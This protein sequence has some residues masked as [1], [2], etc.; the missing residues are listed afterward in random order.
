MDRSDVEEIKARLPIEEVVG[1]YVKLEKAG[2][3]FKAK[4][5]FHGEK[6]ASFF[7]SPDRG[8]YYCFGCGAKGDI[9]S[10]VEQ[11][12]GLDFKGALKVLAERAGVALR[13]GVPSSA[14]SE[15]EGLFRVME[16][17][18][19][20]FEDRYAA[21]KEAQEYIAK[22][23]VTD[24]TRAEFRIG[25]APEGWHGLHEHLKAKK[26]PN[27]LIEKAGLAKRSEDGTGNYYD[28]F[29][30][31]VMFPLSDS[32][33]RVIAF[34]GRILPRLDDGKTGKYINSPDTP[35]FDKSSVL[36]GLDK[37]KGA[38][39]RLGYSIIVEG[40][41]DLVMSHQAG[42]KNTV[43]ASGTAL[44]DAGS[45]RN[46]VTNNLGL[47]RR[48]AGNAI[49]AFDSDAAGRKAAMRAAGIALSL[50]MDVKIADLQGGKDPADLVL[51]DPEGWKDAL[52][53]AKPIVEFELSNVL[54]DVPD[55][56]KVPKALRER[57]LPFVAAMESATDKAYAVKLISDASDLP[58]QAL[59]DDLKAV[60]AKLKAEAAGA[61]GRAPGGPEGSRGAGSGPAG[62][63]GGRQ[64][65]SAASAPTRLDLVERR[66][67][68]LLGLMER[69]GAPKAAEYRTMIANIAQ[70]SFE[71]MLERIKPFMGD[72]SFEAEAFYGSDPGRWDIHMAD[73]IANFEE[74]LVNA[75]LISAMSRLRAAE[76]AGDQ[77]RVA[78]IAKECQG[79]SARKADAVK[80][81]RT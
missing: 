30:G 80:R 18:T 26:H 60:E 47:L 28:R 67:I 6:T 56:R 49:I 59:R 38:I 32:S 5:P 69:S 76:R 36:Y 10:F 25:W 7:V 41:M 3:S 54:R 70:G 27:E 57:V 46:G 73:L 63:D 53:S 72:I 20:Y 35:L 48:L 79:L 58:E 81:R 17:A 14:D 75:A 68:G 42:V 13:S 22:R 61:S 43:A 71:Q 23:G 31:R 4:C 66:M 8:G 34:S 9:F 16:E 44:A 12:E 51:A 50:G 40:Q 19:K 33:G 78:E 2:A 64:A 24:K 55:A 21:S 15:R 62:Q 45:D 1:A 29:R 65:P 77:A 39:R 11:F 52:R 74:D 37:A